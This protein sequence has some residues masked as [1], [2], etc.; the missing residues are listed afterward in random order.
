VRSDSDLIKHLDKIIGIDAATVYNKLPLFLMPE[1]AVELLRHETQMLDA[2]TPILNLPFDDFLLDLPFGTALQKVFPHAGCPDRG[3]MWVRVRRVSAVRRDAG[4][5]LALSHLA[6][7][8]NP[9][10][11]LLLE[12]WEQKTS[13]G[14]M[15]PSPDFSL[16]PMMK[17][18]YGMF[19]RCWHAYP[20]AECLDQR[21]FDLWCNYK[22]CPRCERNPD[23]FLSCSMSELFHASLC[24]YVVLALIYI[25]E[26]LGGMLTEV[27][28]KPAKEKEV[29]SERLK[30]WTVDR[31]Q[32]YILIDPARSG[33]YGHPS[34]GRPEATGTHVSPVPH[35]RR[36]HWRTLSDR[37]TWVRPTWVGA[38]EWQSEGRTYRLKV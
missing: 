7:V 31:R 22:G 27:S 35:S 18:D 24:R 9:D 34:G 33:E 15:A 30:P 8:K 36:G 4:T 14:G 32:T 13:T 11:W 26:G 2:G 38:K 16:V 37:R 28:W 25:T 5:K 19:D 10:Q 17:P 20:N 23:I 12:G 3:R 6:M 29:K 1:E 21:L